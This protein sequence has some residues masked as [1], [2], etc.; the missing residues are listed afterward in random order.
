PTRPWPGV[1]QPTRD[2]S[3]GVYTVQSESASRTREYSVA[4]RLALIERLIPLEAPAVRPNFVERKG[5][6]AERPQAL[7]KLF[8]TV[9]A[10]DDPRLNPLDT[11]YELVIVGMIGQGN[12]IV[13]T[14]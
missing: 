6:V 7:G 3:P 13:V 2:N 9:R 5:I 8:G 11:L 10:I 1:A 4:V 12:A 14:L